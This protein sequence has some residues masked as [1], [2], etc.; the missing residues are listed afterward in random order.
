LALKVIAVPSVLEGSQALLESPALLA[1]M[2]SEAL[3][4]KLALM[5][6]MVLAVFPVP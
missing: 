5:V 2:A 3:T 6:L 4:A 1:K